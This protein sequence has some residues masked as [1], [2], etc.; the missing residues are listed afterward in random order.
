VKKEHKLPIKMGQLLSFS[1]KLLVNRF[2]TDQEDEVLAKI[3]QEELKERLQLAA[4]KQ[5]LVV[6]HVATK[7]SNQYETVSGF[8]A[9]KKINGSHIIVKS[10]T[11]KKQLRMIAV[12]TIV[13]MSQLPLTPPE[14]PAH[15]A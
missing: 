8:I 12:E 10:A 4:T 14:K 5:V 6:L 1:S 13:K 7:K 11:A 9:T 2:L 3:Q 15:E